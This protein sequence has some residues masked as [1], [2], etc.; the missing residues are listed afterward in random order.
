MPIEFRR[1]SRDILIVSFFVVKS[2]FFAAPT[3]FFSFFFLFFFCCRGF[4]RVSFP[5]R[6]V[7]EWKRK[8]QNQ[9]VKQE[10]KEKDSTRRRSAAFTAPIRRPRRRPIN[11]ESPNK[12][13]TAQIKDG[14]FRGLEET[15]R[16]LERGSGKDVVVG[17]VP[18]H[19]FL[20]AMEQSERNLSF[21]CFL[22]GALADRNDGALRH[23]PHGGGAQRRRRRRGVAAVA[24]AQHHRVHRERLDG[25]AAS[26]LRPRLRRQRLLVRGVGARP[27][28]RPGRSVS[29]SPVSFFCSFLVRTWIEIGTRPLYVHFLKPKFIFSMLKI[30][31]TWPLYVHFLNRC[32]SFSMFKIVKTSIAIRTR[33]LYAQF[34]NRY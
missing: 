18:G 16:S 29:L 25:V 20:W 9:I 14:L 10:R 2:S 8:Q 17:D 34:L 22:S 19:R 33:P 21:V 5:F 31:R 13:M 3:V 23:V 26:A 32:I 28:A 24:G 27:S 4:G 15:G 30:V 11:V 6:R 12:P 7:L 1:G